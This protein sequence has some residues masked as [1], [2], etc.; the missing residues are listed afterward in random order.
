[1]ALLIAAGAITLIV[2]ERTAEPG[3]ARQSTSLSAMAAVVQVAGQLADGKFDEIASRLEPGPPLNVDAQLLRVEWSQ[4]F[5]AYG[6]YRSVGAP[7]QVGDVASAPLSMARGQVILAVAVHPDGHL[8]GVGFEP[9]ISPNPP[10]LS[11]GFLAPRAIAEARS[12]DDSDFQAAQQDFDPLLRAESG[13]TQLRAT[14]QQVLRAFGPI[15]SVGGP[16]LLGEG[17]YGTV[18]NTPLNMAGGQL[19]LQVAFDGNGQIRLVEP[20]LPNPTS[21]TL[22][23]I[24]SPPTLAAANLA[25]LLVDELVNGS[26]QSVA[27][28]FNHLAAANLTT[29]ALEHQW[30]SVSGRLGRIR[31]T[32]SPDLIGGTP[33]VVSY[34]I[35]VTY[36][37]GAAHVQISFDR[38]NRVQELFIGTGPPSRIFGQ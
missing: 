36:T 25:Q 2:S 6:A 27:A 16:V 18:V 26:Y 23:G 29:T 35:G 20:L 19:Y 28:A 7:T 10:V 31:S 13:L 14:W 1:V 34:E 12:L 4:V 22:V 32:S 3:A 21:E 33:S 9:G 11:F 24:G 30:L 15:R 37:D 38:A 5:Q 8:Y 17:T